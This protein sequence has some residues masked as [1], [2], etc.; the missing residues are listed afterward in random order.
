MSTENQTM[1]RKTS[2]QKYDGARHTYF[3]VDPSYVL[4]IGVD[5]HHK[6]IEE[7]CLYQEPEE[8]H[9]EWIE[10]LM[11]KGILEPVIVRKEG[12]DAVV[13]AGRRRTLGL[14]EANKR[15]VAAGK[16]PH[17]LPIL[18]E[19]GDDN[20]SLERMIIENM[21]RR[22]PNPMQ[23]A[24]LLKA[25][26]DRE[27]NKAKSDQEAAV[28]FHCTPTTI[29]NWKK[30]WDLDPKVQKA[31]M[32]GE[33]SPNAAS[34]LSDLEPAEQRKKFSDL[35]KKA[36]ESGDKKI[37]TRHTETERQQRKGSVAAVAYT[38]PKATVLRKVAED[39][40]A[41]SK[42][43]SLVQSVLRYVVGLADGSDI[44]ELLALVQETPG[45]GKRKKSDFKPTKA[46]Q[47]V[48]DLIDEAKGEL[49]ASQAKKGAMDSLIKAGMIERYEG[50]DGLFYL[51]KTEAG[52]SL[53]RSEDD[54]PSSDGGSSS[55]G[56]GAESNG[57]SDSSK[58][59]A[60]PIVETSS[61]EV[62]IPSVQELEEMSSKE[63]NRVFSELKISTDKLSGLKGREL[64]TRK[65]ELI[66][67]EKRR[68]EKAAKKA[69]SSQPVAEA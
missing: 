56:E 46:Q 36:E 63:L 25:W 42:L 57:S 26:W 61:D 24:A 19:D 8:L 58:P 10:G 55:S 21:A 69:S 9:E 29:R 28:V 2:K 3:G 33:I 52:A 48:L 34:D 31:V 14:R 43:P 38:P 27:E 12:E 6:S 22:D 7:H 30:L 17:E 16:K 54:E 13:I 32:Q 11:N 23:K 41:M 67:A 15:L 20:D 1:P 5:T 66:L 62:K 37:T 47:S 64:Q 50:K 51:K 45:R 68:R 39:P 59:S 49:L 35:K 53:G 40:E 44:P 4:V 18:S 65:V 60:E